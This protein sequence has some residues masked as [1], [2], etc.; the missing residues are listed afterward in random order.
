MK[1]NRKLS[2]LLI[3]SFLICVPA[4]ISHKIVANV[5]DWRQSNEEIFDRHITNN[6]EHP[7]ANPVTKYILV[8]LTV[9]AGMKSVTITSSCDRSSF[10]S[11]GGHDSPGD[12]IDKL[13]DEWFKSYH[14]GDFCNALDYHF[15]QY[16]G[17]NLAENVRLYLDKFFL[18]AKQVKDD[19]Y[20]LAN[21]GIGLYFPQCIKGQWSSNGLI[22]H[23]DFRGKKG[24]WAR[25][26]GKY[27]KIKQGIG[28][29]RKDL[30]ACG[31]D[32]SGFKDIEKGWDIFTCTPSHD[33]ISQN[34]PVSL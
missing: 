21:T 25:V 8:N 31:L 34:G 11:H 32:D 12:D 29:F 4:V 24:R 20:L 5:V 15:D 30:K 13:L 19:K 16:I 6:R 23:L 2:N 28:Q 7:N 26:R 27:V 10:F 22:G 3:T 9:N 17:R 14:H 18:M 1:L 33:T